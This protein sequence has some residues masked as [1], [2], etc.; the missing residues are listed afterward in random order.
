MVHHPVSVGAR[1][2]T[3]GHPAPQLQLGL[4]RAPSWRWWGWVEVRLILLEKL[5]IFSALG[6]CEKWNFRAIS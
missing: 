4:E 3:P 6:K 1:D 5:P 2:L